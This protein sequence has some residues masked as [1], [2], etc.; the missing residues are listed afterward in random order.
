[1]SARH[2]FSRGR[3]LQS[4]WTS[5]QGRSMLPPC[6]RA[7]SHPP[8]PG[9]C[10][11]PHF[12]GWAHRPFGGGDIPTRLPVGISLPDIG[13]P[14]HASAGRHH[15]SKRQ[16][17]RTTRHR[18]VP[19]THGPATAP[20]S[21]ETRGVLGQQARGSRVTLTC[22]T[23]EDRRSLDSRRPACPAPVPTAADPIRDFRLWRSWP[24]VA[25]FGH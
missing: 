9:W 15:R 12:E 25:T 22:G 10:W 7:G 2:K 19:V 16:D 21:C 24:P 20:E 3:A 1:L 5:D 4:A 14:P 23:R 17:P 11:P 6:G 8:K 18:R 13:G